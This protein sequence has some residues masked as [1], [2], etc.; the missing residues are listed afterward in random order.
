MQSYTYTVY[1]MSGQKLGMGVS[2]NG[3]ERPDGPA[4]AAKWGYGYW[5]MATDP[6]AE[7]GIGNIGV[8]V[9]AGNPDFVLLWAAEFPEMS[10]YNPSPGGSGGDPTGG[11][12]Q[13]ATM[14]QSITVNHGI[15]TGVTPVSGFT[16]TVT[17]AAG[18]SLTF[19]NG[20]CTAAT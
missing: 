19:V 7:A 11:A 17:P 3:H 8:Y 1:S 14:I 6:P 2:P 13:A 18:H 5:S 4:L 10:Y 20:V 16:G 9:G 15:V 12:T